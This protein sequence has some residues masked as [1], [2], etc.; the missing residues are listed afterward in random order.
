M[1]QS[2]ITKLIAALFS[3]II[4]AACSSSP[5]KPTRQAAIEP[6]SF[7][8]FSQ[9]RDDYLCVDAYNNNLYCEKGDVNGDGKDDIVAFDQSR[10]R[11]IVA[12][13]NGI[14]FPS[15]A[16]RVWT[17]SGCSSGQA[18]RTGDVNGDGKADAIIFERNIGDPVLHGDVF[19]QLS[20]GSGFGAKQKWHPSFCTAADGCYMGDVNGDGKDDILS[21]GSGGVYAAFSTGHSFGV[22]T[23]R[24]DTLCSYSTSVC[25]VGDFNGDGKTDLISFYR[26][27]PGPTRGRVYVALS[28][29]STYGPKT[30]WRENFCSGLKVTCAVGNIAGEGND[31]KDDI[32]AFIHYDVGRQ[33]RVL[34]AQSTGASFGA[35]VSQLEGFCFMSGSTC[36]A[37]N[38]DGVGREDLVWL[39]R[40]SEYPIRGDAYVAKSQ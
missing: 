35:T 6:Q 30:L 7:N 20:N 23:K 15:Y 1:N 21:I 34:T 32:I 37:G 25:D 2:S 28:N 17:Y 24:A 13:S 5:A 11:T 12:P 39:V 33:S 4:L 19:V 8:T 22:S 9:W 38:F 36:L 3:L 10:A 26:E 29:G 27:T 31:D 14:S 16:M 18:C 40:N